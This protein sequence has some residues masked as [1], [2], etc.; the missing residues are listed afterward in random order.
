[1]DMLPVT[2]ALIKSES[3]AKG[4]KYFYTQFFA[5]DGTTT[6]GYNIFAM[7]P[8]YGLQTIITSGADITDFEAN[9]KP[10]A[11]S[12]GDQSSAVA[13]AEL[14]QISSIIL[15]GNSSGRSFGY[16]ATSAASS[17]TVRATTYTPQGTNSQR[18]VNSTAAADTGAGTGAQK[19]KI[20]YFDA[21]GAGPFTETVT[22]NGVTAVNTVNTNIALIERMDV[23]QVGSGGGNAGTIQI[24]TA[25][26]GGGSVWGSIATG[27][28]QTH[29]AHHYV[30]PNKTCYVTSIEGSATVVAG[31]L[32][33]NTANP[34]SAAVPQTAPDIT[35]RHGTTHA[36]R[37]YNVPV[38]VVGP[39]IIFINERPDA[40]T[41]S[42]TFSGFSWIQM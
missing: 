27:D 37:P 17:K 6:V 10:S 1:M 20:T 39:A 16:T 32:T 14:A 9:I 4:L 3:A 31:G 30:P 19:V 34:I 5:A 11:T 8:V 21:L 29:W 38:P 26:A 13:M 12:A 42:T 28:N 15:P 24:W 23:V 40:A 18:S 33:I 22:L 36:L 41:A 35:I 25:T 2:Y 7:S